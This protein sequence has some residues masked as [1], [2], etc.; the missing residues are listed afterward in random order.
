[1]IL[2]AAEAG[3]LVPHPPDLLLRPLGVPSAQP[4]P[5]EVVLLPHRL[6]IGSRIG[7][8]IRIGGDVD[9]PQVHADEVIRLH[10]RAIG[11]PHR[12]VEVELAVAIAQIDLASE[13]VES[14]AVVFAEHHGD[15]LASFQR[16]QADDI[17]PLEAEDAFVVGDGAMRLEDGAD[18]L[19]SP[20]ALHRLGYGPDRQLRREAKPLADLAVGQLVERWLRED[21]GLESDVGREARGLVEPPHHGEQERLLRSSGSNRIR[22]ARFMCIL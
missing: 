12:G 5:L 9:D 11:D 14:P 16:P 6:D 8:P 2:V 7:V 19:V 13:P 3:L 22:M 21:A 18:R 20:E 10:R 1:M 4:L 15:P 17:E